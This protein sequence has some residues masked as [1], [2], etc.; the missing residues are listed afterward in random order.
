[1]LYGVRRLRF[2]LLA[3]QVSR[4]LGPARHALEQRVVAG[5]LEITYPFKPVRV[6]R[7]G[8]NKPPTVSS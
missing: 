3:L 6:P 4:D 2:P 1:M 5:T 7:A 8:S